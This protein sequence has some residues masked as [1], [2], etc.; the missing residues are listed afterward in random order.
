MITDR[1]HELV[2][3]A[4]WGVLKARLLSDQM[5]TRGVQDCKDQEGRGAWLGRGARRELGL[6]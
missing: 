6:G 1:G 4:E 5:Q 2:N 3:Q